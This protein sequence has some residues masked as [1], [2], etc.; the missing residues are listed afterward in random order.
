MFINDK[1]AI[2]KLIFILLYKI[3]AMLKLT[4]ASLQESS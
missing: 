4:H 1:R 3:Y 2:I